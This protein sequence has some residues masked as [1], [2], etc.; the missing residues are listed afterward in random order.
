MTQ[1]SQIWLPADGWADHE[2]SP[3]LTDSLLRT[4]GHGGRDH[5]R[6]D[7]MGNVPGEKVRPKSRPGTVGRSDLRQVRRRYPSA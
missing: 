3:S 5:C 6:W 2:R 7:R 4:Y 1:S